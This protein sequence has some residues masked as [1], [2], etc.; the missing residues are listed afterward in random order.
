MKKRNVGRF[1]V[2]WI[3]WMYAVVIMSFAKSEQCSYSYF[4]RIQRAV[5]R[6][7]LFFRHFTLSI[8]FFFFI[9]T[10]SHPIFIDG[11]LKKYDND[12]QLILNKYLKL[13]GW[14]GSVRFYLMRFDS[15]E[16]KQKMEKKPT[17]L[18]NWLTSQIN[19]F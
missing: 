1:C 11:K 6:C 16:Y 4:K 8:Q 2:C 5:C 7:F 3:C 19:L 13:F 10:L 17:I 15:G 14:F 18:E 12:C 9:F